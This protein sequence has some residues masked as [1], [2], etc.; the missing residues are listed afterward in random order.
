MILGA[1]GRVGTGFQHMAQTGVWPGA[2]LP[3][4]HGRTAA[5]GLPFV[6]DMD[7]PLPQNVPKAH[8]VLC[9]AGATSGPDLEANTRAAK[10][11]VDLARKHD[12]G[13]VFLMSSAAVY[14]R[15]K[16]R[17]AED[18][19][20]T[21]AN[22]YGAAKRDME[23][24]LMQSGA[25]LLRVAN[26]AGFDALFG[27]MSRGIVRLDQFADG[28]GPRRAYVGPVTLA[29]LIEDLRNLPDLPPILN[30]AQPGLVAMQDVLEAANHPFDW[31]DA[32]QGALP[33]M[34]LDVSL[35]DAIRPLPRADAAGLVA[36][37]RLAG[38]TAEGIAA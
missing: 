18:E 20:P 30:I 22:A 32:P 35:L 1:T 17:Q 7:E 4:F 19:T 37:A 28:R 26:V 8:G 34:A 24:A 6:W 36:E 11:A 13:P 23:L 27:S 12:L 2:A 15:A 16:G 25:T 31:Q 9:L 38:W 14:G 21:P 5:A 3:V 33:E 10:A 29:K